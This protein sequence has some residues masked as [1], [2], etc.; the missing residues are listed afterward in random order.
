MRTI[1]IFLLGVIAGCFIYW[2]AEK[3]MERVQHYRDSKLMQ[4]EM[5]GCGDEGYRQVFEK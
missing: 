1:I 5:S 4:I 3:A 2:Q